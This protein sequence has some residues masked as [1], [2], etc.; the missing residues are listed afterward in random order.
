MRSPIPY[1]H[2]GCGCRYT[3]LDPAST[4][5]IDPVTGIVTYENLGSALIPSY[6]LTVKATVTFANLSQVECLIPFEVK[7]LR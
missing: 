5:S 4:F 2:V 7:G 3:I 1:L 6:N